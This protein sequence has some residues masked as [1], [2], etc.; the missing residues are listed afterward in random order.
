[1]NLFCP[2]LS[3][4]NQHEQIGMDGDLSLSIMGI[5]EMVGLDKLTDGK[6]FLV[7]L[8]FILAFQFWEQGFKYIGEE[9]NCSMMGVL[10]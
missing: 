6:C 2:N 8:I 9:E 1:L 3:S 4:Y 5:F 10:V 7:F